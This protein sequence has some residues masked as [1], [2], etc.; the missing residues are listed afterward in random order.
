[1]ETS[2]AIRQNKTPTLLSECSKVYHRLAQVA[3]VVAKWCVVV[4]ALVSIY[5]VAL[6]MTSLHL[7]QTGQLSHYITDHHGQLSIPSLWVG[8]S[9][10]SLPAWCYGGAHSP[11]SGSR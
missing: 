11:V 7:G 3:T 10:T 6:R 4:K 2:R 1:M 9:S 5:K 8:K